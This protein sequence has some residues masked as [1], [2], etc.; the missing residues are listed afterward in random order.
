MSRDTR[1]ARGPMHA[2][3]LQRALAPPPVRA[4]QFEAR[5]YL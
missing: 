3:Q 2:A 5:T 4:D 1:I